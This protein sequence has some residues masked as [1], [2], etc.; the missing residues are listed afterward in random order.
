MDQ[1]KLSSQKIQAKHRKTSCRTKNNV[2]KALAD[3]QR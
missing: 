2:T 1:K 3:P